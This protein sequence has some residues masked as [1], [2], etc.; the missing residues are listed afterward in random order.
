MIEKLLKEEKEIQKINFNKKIIISKKVKNDF[1]NAKS[2]HICN[3]EYKKADV[4]ARDHYHVTGKYRGS[5]HANC[6]LSY[7]LTH[8]IYVIF[9]NLR[10]Y[11]SHLIMQEIGKFNKD[12]NV[13]PNNME[14]YMAFMIGNLIFT[15]SFQFMN[16]SLSNLANNLPKNDFYHTENKFGSNN[17]ELITKKSIYPYAYMDDFNKFKEEGLPLIEKKYSK[18]TGEDISD[19][20]YNHAKNVWERFKCK[21]IGDY[22]DLYLTSDVLILADVFEKFRKTSKQYYNLDPVHYFSCPGFA[23]DA[24]LKMIGI[25]LELITDIDMYQMVA[26]GLRGGT[27]YIANRY[28]EPNNKYMCDYDKDKESSYLMYLDVNNLY[29]CAMSQP[30]PTG[31]FKW[32][33]EDK[34]DDIL[35]NKEGIAYFIECDLEYPKKLYD[36]HNDYPLAPEKLIVQ[37]DWLSPFCKNLKEKFDLASHKTTKLIPTLFNKKQNMYYML[38]ILIYTRS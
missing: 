25:N 31:G 20:D 37:D 30:L 11:D 8:K 28:S 29:G 6:N 5:A 26:K 10:G 15:V 23:W 14:K 4:P 32:L 24:M 12:I 36:L 19:S 7:R 13:S 18:L 21:T 35:K 33:K 17:L 27:S 3:K 38:E 34:G 2:C 22:H 16:Q 1:K 9:H